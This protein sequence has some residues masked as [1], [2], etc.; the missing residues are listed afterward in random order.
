[1]DAVPAYIGESGKSRDRY[2]P[3]E[4][5]CF[6]RRDAVQSTS[7]RTDP[8]IYALYGIIC[9]QRRCRIDVSAHRLHQGMPFRAAFGTRFFALLRMT[10]LVILSGAVR[11]SEGSEAPHRPLLRVLE[12]IPRF[13]RNDREDALYQILR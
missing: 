7:L 4:N 2:S 9:A 12:Q 8:S 13:A 1:M 5:G 3:G 10:F 11:R 6:M